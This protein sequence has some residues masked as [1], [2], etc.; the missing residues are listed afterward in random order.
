MYRI[1]IRGKALRSISLR[2]KYSLRN[3]TMQEL[4]ADKQPDVQDSGKF[5]TKLF[6]SFSTWPNGES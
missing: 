5:L 2:H 3:G 1:I 4:F 6:F